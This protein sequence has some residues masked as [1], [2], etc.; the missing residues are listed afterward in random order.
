MILPVNKLQ[1][2]ALVGSYLSLQGSNL[3]LLLSA[4]LPQLRQ[5]LL[6][7]LQESH[8]GASVSC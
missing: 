3:L 7:D 5:V 6:I 4:L 2:E 8:H 1:A